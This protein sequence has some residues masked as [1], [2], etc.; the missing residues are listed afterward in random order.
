VL[1]SPNKPLAQPPPRVVVTGAGIVTALGIGWRQ[2]AEGFRAGRTAFRP[3]SLFDVSRQRV[4]TAAEVTLP[5]TLPAT[6]LTPRQAGRLDRA[7]WMLLLAAHEAWLQSG[8]EAAEN[9]PLVLGTTAG[10]MSLGE[11]YFRTALQQ[12]GRRRGQ[13]T[14]ALHY[15]AQAQGRTLASALGFAG[16]VWIVSN[17]CAAGA[18]A[19]GHAWE[20]IRRGQAE[21]AMAGGHDALSQLVFAGFDVLQALSPTCC[22]P[23]DARRDGLALGEGAAVLTLETLD[24]ARKRGALI[25]GEI[26][27]YG[28]T[29]D[30]YHLTQPQPQG[31]AALTSMALACQSAGVT[32]AEV[33]YVNAHG[34]GTA[35]NDSAE[36]AAINRWAGTRAATLPVSS[37]K[38]SI[39]HLLGGAGAVEAIIC[40]MA[41][42]GQWLP[43]ETTIE[44]PD[45]ACGFP[46]VSK[47]RDARLEVALSNSFG[48]GGVN[49]SLIFRRWA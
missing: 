10:G 23:F 15:Q 42:R 48:F 2:N 40:L 38:A 13:P 12:P 4:K 5:E 47:P 17:A 37:T 31:E 36:A 6:R 21:Q 32:P 33:G 3:V 25:A 29:F 24:R 35:L 20:L 46:V 27:G 45:P 22:R 8:W 7:G 1:F 44:T 14:R 49:A 39:G 16:P 11:A 34:T 41:L 19:I 43:P 26:I 28:T 9:L 30:S 18:S